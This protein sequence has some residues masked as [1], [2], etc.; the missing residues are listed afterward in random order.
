MDTSSDLLATMSTSL[1]SF[2]QPT[3]VLHTATVDA[4]KQLLDPLALDISLTQSHRRQENRKKRKRSQVDAESQVLQIRE[5]YTNGFGIHQVWEQARRVLDAAASELE[6][7][8]QQLQMIKSKDERLGQ[9]P[10]DGNARLGVKML[11]FE[12]EGFEVGSD[13]DSDD[14]DL[15]EGEEGDLIEDAGLEKP[16]DV[17]DG[18][19]AEEDIEALSEDDR[20]S[21]EA[22]AEQEVFRPDPNGLNDGFFSI[23]DFNKQSQF[24]EEK[25]AQ[26]EDDNPS[27]EDDIDWDADP[28]T[29][30]F[31][32][33]KA[34]TQADPDDDLDEKE[35]DEGPG[36]G[37][38]DLDAPFS[39]DDEEALDGEN[40]PRGAMG[41]L[42]NT[43]EIR[44]ADFFEPPP[45]RPSKS[46][47]MR[48]LPKTQ[49]TPKPITGGAT[50]EAE[51]ADMERAISDV[52]RD[53]LDSEDNESSANEA[54]SDSETGT[55]RPSKAA[56]LSTHEKQR[57]LVAAE[58]RKLEAA[59]VSKRD[60]TLSGEARA[61]DRPMNSLI[62]EDL[63]FDRVGKPVPVITAE[64]SS[65]IE[66]LIKRRI[67]ARDFDEVIRRR[68]ETARSAENQRRGA[69]ELDDS[70]SKTGLADLYEAEHL[71][72]T[73]P[74]YVDSRSAATKKQH[75]EIGALWREV[76]AQLDL[77][78]NLHFRPKRPQAEIQVVGDKPTISMEDARPGGAAEDIGMLAPQE[79]YRPG[80]EK[81]G[82]GEVRT[83]GGQ[84]LAK[85]E[86]SREE[87]LRR[88]RREKERGKKA[89]GSDRVVK[90]AGPGAKKGKREEKEDILSQLK[91]GGVKVIGGK[92]EVEGLGR[93]G[94]GREQA[95]VGSARSVKL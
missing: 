57:A 20:L 35:D 52:R 10:A 1:H 74:N 3:P 69:V 53:L 60:W 90:K 50:E 64:V 65:E 91:R 29:M 8:L 42:D 15:T 28:L 26:G 59:N 2:L 54:H 95:V 94:K 62:E 16:D 89:K 86:L 77:L 76:S 46:K 17:A 11:R 36:F 71:S 9:I 31:N 27:D 44:Y 68:P 12:D 32:R 61:A 4:A 41:G 38:A 92:G 6:N 39:E 78:S 14:A 18:G 82:G 66:A 85:E 73:D 22:V 24:L 25:D 93:K 34:G 83:K 67:I 7:D 63:A 80:E 49:P 43:N 87:K 51:Q 70:K 55:A 45:K 81:A 72:K 21:D 23:D 19:M 47:R 84:S 48:A 37:N 58:I 79:V 33:P 30:S 5:V 13:R 40:D 75:A 56:N 88:R